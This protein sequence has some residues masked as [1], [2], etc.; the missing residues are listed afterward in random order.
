MIQIWAQILGVGLTIYDTLSFLIFEPQFLHLSIR[1]STYFFF[2]V[3]VRLRKN[4]CNP[5]GGVYGNG[6]Y[7]FLLAS[8]KRRL[9]YSIP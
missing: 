7:I 2:K 1:I 5:Y 6:N 3:L 4:I 9:G 8:R